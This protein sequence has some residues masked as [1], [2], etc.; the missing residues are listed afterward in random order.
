M[1]RPVAG[2]DYTAVVVVKVNEDMK[3]ALLGLLPS[4]EE[5]YIVEDEYLDVMEPGTEVLDM[6]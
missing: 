2:D 1:R 6:S 5:L 4:A 3:E